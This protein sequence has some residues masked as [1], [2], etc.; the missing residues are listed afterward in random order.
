M[1]GAV[2]G[3][4]VTWLLG[5]QNKGRGMEGV[6]W[7]FWLWLAILDHSAFHGSQ[8]RPAVASRLCGRVDCDLVGDDCRD[9]PVVMRGVDAGIFLDAEWVRNCARH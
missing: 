4:I 8:I 3:T 9:I 6:G 7:W 5:T 2:S 1:A